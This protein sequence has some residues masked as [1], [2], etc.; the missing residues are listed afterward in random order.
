MKNNPWFLPGGNTAASSRSCGGGA[1]AIG[2]CIP[3]PTSGSG[4]YDAGGYFWSPILLLPAHP[5]PSRA[6]SKQNFSGRP[7]GFQHGDRI[8]KL[9]GK[10]REKE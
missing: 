5:R 2:G 4:G 8:K 7:A 3:I 1:V 10:S 6:Q 9:S